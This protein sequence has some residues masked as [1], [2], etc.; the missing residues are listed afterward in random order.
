MGESIGA[1]GECGLGAASIG[2]IRRGDEGDVARRP[3]R[4]AESMGRRGE[5]PR[6]VRPEATAKSRSR[7][8]AQRREKEVIMG[9]DVVKNEA[10]KNWDKPWSKEV[11]DLTA[12]LMKVIVDEEGDK[13]KAAAHHVDMG[14]WQLLGSLFNEDSKTEAFKKWWGSHAPKELVHYKSSTLSEKV[15]AGATKVLP[16]ASTAKAMFD[17]MHALQEKA[18]AA[19]R[20]RSDRENCMANMLAVYLSEKKK[21]DEAAIFLTMFSFQASSAASMGMGSAGLDTLVKQGAKRGLWL[22]QK[23]IEAAKD[24]L[25]EKSAQ[26]EFQEALAGVKGKGSDLVLGWATY[27]SA[28][29]RN[30][31]KAVESCRL[32][33][34]ASLGLPYE[35]DDFMARGADVAAMVKALAGDDT[36]R[37]RV[38]SGELVRLFK[39][40]TDADRKDDIEAIKS[41]SKGRK[42]IPHLQNFLVVMGVWDYLQKNPYKIS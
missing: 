13:I 31:G 6:R 41:F 9:T 24:K 12:K 3:R 1:A 26:S 29:P 35:G 16:G 30:N 32:A 5:R 21:A 40:V 37:K 8:G 39:S 28:P 4:R 18:N 22:A 11:Q 36:S 23:G 2:W 38:E 19:S 27:L 34:R 33:L 20:M 10:P 42:H 15:V 25:V 14:L 7:D 17:S